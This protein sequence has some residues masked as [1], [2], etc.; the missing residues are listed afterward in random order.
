MLKEFL[1]IFI[2]T[3][4]VSS[5]STKV[6]MAQDS[7]KNYIQKISG[8][9]KNIDMIFIQ[10]GV[11]LMGSEEKGWGHKPDE[12]PAHQVRVSSFWMSDSEITWNLYN[13]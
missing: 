1:S 7:D 2:I 9:D 13:I 8:T 4:L 11:F 12:A 3:I 6:M 5:L 10:E